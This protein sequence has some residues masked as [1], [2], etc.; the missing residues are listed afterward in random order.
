L[1]IMPSSPDREAHCSAALGIGLNVD[2]SSATK[3]HDDVPKPVQLG[4]RLFCGFYNPNEERDDNSSSASMSRMSYGSR[5]GII[6]CCP[7]PANRRNITA[8]EAYN[9]GMLLSYFISNAYDMSCVSCCLPGTNT[10]E[11]LERRW[12]GH[13]PLVSD[14]WAISNDG[15]SPYEHRNMRR[16]RRRG[17][18]S[19]AMMSPSAREDNINNDDISISSRMEDSPRRQGWK[20]FVPSNNPA[21]R[22]GD[23]IRMDT[24]YSSL[25]KGTR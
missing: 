20:T 10:R 13:Q 19:S 4:D 3:V 7:P 12:S 23:D 11:D 14:T 17:V 15:M 9:R 25:M 22:V 21:Q 5:G 8:K 18:V 24:H 2:T 1:R 6:P 16:R